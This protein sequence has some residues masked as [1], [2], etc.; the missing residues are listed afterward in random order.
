MELQED[1]LNTPYEKMR[2]QKKLRSKK[3]KKHVND[4]L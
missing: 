2:Q 3:G 1:T 4:T